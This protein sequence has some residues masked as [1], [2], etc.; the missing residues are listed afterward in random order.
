MNNLIIDNIFLSHDLRCGRLI[1]SSKS[2]YLAKYESIEQKNKVIFNANIIIND[3]GKIW[4]GDLD[5]NVDIQKLQ[6]I[7]IQLNTPLYILR[8]MDCRFGNEN[9]PI[10]SLIKKSVI[11]IHAHTN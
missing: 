3:L 2:G 5:C 10:N 7:A 6:S 4:F 11:T 9:L 1:A 8:E